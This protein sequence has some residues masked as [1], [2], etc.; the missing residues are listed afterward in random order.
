M[1]WFKNLTFRWKFFSPVVLVIILFT[2]L[3]TVITVVS[4]DQAKAGK[5]LTDEV[6]P[7]EEELDDGYRDM[8][9]IIAA[10]QGVIL[11]QYN[12]ERLRYF[13]EEFYDDVPKALPRL[14]S[15]KRL[16]DIGFLDESNRQRLLKLEM[17]YNRWV[18][19]YRI[20]IDKPESAEDYYE[21]NQKVIEREFDELRGFVKAF[22]HEIQT[23]QAALKA[24][25]DHQLAM[26]TRILQIGLISTIVISLLISWGV[27]GLVIAPIKRLSGA[28]ND[29]ATGDGDLTQRIDV[30]SRD[31]VGQLAG[32]FNEFVSKIHRTISEVAVTMKAVQD[33]TRQI[34]IQTEGVVKNAV[35]Q[36]KESTL[37]ATAVHEMSTTSDDV[38]SHANEA[39]AASQSASTGSETAKEVLGSTVASIYQ[40]ADEIESASGVIGNLEQD[41]GNIASILDVIRGIADQTNLLALN[42]AI[43]AARAGDQG[44]GFAVVADEV[45]TLASK[46]QTSTGE[47]QVM[48]ERLQ[49]GAKAA[50]QAMES[51]R[52]CG[53]TT[54][55]QAQTAT[56]SID[57][58]SHSINVINDMNVQI[59]AAATQQSQVSDG[60]NTNVQ[61]IADMSEEMVGNVEATGQAFDTLARQCQ[62]LERLLGQFRL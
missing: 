26:A 33:E 60:I 54:V 21:E 61:V 9:Q 31:E 32:S 46:T 37:V 8:Y 1:Q 62:Q 56:E 49:N 14:L 23:S 52:T 57:A 55:V 51:S 11:S 6:L 15:P 22:R 24:H 25:I 35:K 43:E 29:I 17:A 40:L 18:A 28:M 4:H 34:H 44:R 58:I 48:I 19:H 13:Q 20:M 30:E 42:A 36:R 7:V 53:N 2:A 16:I 45:R 50:V 10:G 41:V 3:F 12:P 47:I 39:A 27:S 59:A 5:L 38:S